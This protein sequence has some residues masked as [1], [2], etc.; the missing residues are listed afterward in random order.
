[1][2]AHFWYFHC[3]CALLL[4]TLHMIAYCIHITDVCIC[5]AHACIVFTLRVSVFEI[6]CVGFANA[7]TYGF[8]V[9]VL[10]LR[11]HGLCMAD[12]CAAHTFRLIARVAHTRL[13]CTRLTCTH[14]DRTN[15]ARVARMCTAHTHI[16]PYLAHTLRHCSNTNGI[17]ASQTLRTFVFAATGITLPLQILVAHLYLRLLVAR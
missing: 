2:S 6:P 12:I 13:A 16:A 14:V 17:N 3:K 8:A 11:I 5:S 1:M 15:I 7:C 4:F 9:Q 10:V